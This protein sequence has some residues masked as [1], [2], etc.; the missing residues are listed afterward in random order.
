MVKNWKN[1]KRLGR[2]A[3]TCF[4]GRWRGIKASFTNISSCNKNQRYPS[5]PLDSFPLVGFYC[6]EIASFAGQ[7][8]WIHFTSLSQSEETRTKHWLVHSPF[9]SFIFA[10]HKMSFPG[11]FSVN[12]LRKTRQKQN[13]FQ[14]PMLLNSGPKRAYFASS[15]LRRALT[16]ME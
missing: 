2:C 9:R 5:N 7:P 6:D 3:V 15:Y 11:H 8:E 16:G 1:L 13:S 14:Q 12:S 10:L 4:R